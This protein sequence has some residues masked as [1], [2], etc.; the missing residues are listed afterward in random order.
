MVPRALGSGHLVV[1]LLVG[2]DDEAIALAVDLRHG[3]AE[4]RSLVRLRVD[5][6]VPE[7]EA[8]AER[9][10]HDLIAEGEDLDLVAD[11]AR[12]DGKAAGRGNQV[13]F[14]R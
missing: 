1:A 13:S 5:D 4:I 6:R 10:L 7:R 3:L 9:N 2:K 11:L 8:A 12:E 14:H